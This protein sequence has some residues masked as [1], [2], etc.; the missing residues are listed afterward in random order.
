MSDH[1]VT[2]KLNTPQI[3]SA[4]ADRAVF[5]AGT[6]ML[7]PLSGKWGHHLADLEQTKDLSVI[8]AQP[9]SAVAVKLPAQAN[10]ASSDFV[11]EGYGTTDPH[12]SPLWIKTLGL[13]LVGAGTRPLAH[14]SPRKSS[15]PIS[16]PSVCRERL[17]L[18]KSSPV[19]TD[20]WSTAPGRL[21]PL[22]GSGQ[23][24]ISKNLLFTAV[25]SG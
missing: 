21:Q 25:C 3:F 6:W 16:C 15:V 20:R 23:G 2:T 19:F 9:R 17:G 12:R 14:S 1:V 7:G 4:W 11:R 10:H 13:L 8:A 22:G 5:V 24:R 18:Q